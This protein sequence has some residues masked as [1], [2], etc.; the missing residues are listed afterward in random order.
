MSGGLPVLSSENMPKIA[1]SSKPR[2]IHF[3][4][5]HHRLARPGAK[6]QRR[7]LWELISEKCSSNPRIYLPSVHGFTTRYRL[8]QRGT[9]AA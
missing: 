2:L 4:K 8:I 3:G 7:H 6:R 9:L 1:P 5:D